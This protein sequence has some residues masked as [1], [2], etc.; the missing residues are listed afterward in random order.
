MTTGLPFMP[1]RTRTDGGLEFRHHDIMM[2]S[3]YFDLFNFFVGSLQSNLHWLRSQLPTL[4]AIVE[5]CPLSWAAVRKC[6]AWRWKT[7]NVSGVSSSSVPI[8]PYLLSPIT[9]SSASGNAS[10]ISH[11]IWTNA[12]RHLASA[13]AFDM[14]LPEGSQEI[15][16]QNRACIFHVF[17]N[18]QGG[19]PLVV[20]LAGCDC[21][22]VDNHI[23]ASM[24][25]RVL[26]G[27]VSCRNGEVLEA[28]PT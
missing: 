18:L 5:R 16:L 3:C 23:C 4:H 17:E 14:I 22:T 20:L 25:V 15:H 24:D 7:K 10:S 28:S 8:G 19:F 2:K 21:R 9:V 13:M 27:L 6:K 1:I 12:S 26:S 11:C